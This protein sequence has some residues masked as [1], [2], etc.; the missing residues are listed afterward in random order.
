VHEQEGWDTPARG[1]AEEG[2]DLQ[3][4]TLRRRS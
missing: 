1:V 3:V 2:G 4:R